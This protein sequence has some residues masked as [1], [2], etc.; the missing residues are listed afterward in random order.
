ME[1][2]WKKQTTMT[3]R[4]MRYWQL[5][6]W[7]KFTK[8]LHVKLKKWKRRRF[9]GDG[10]TELPL[11]LKPHATVREVVRNEL[12]KS[13]SRSYK[14]YFYSRM[15]ARWRFYFKYAY[16]KTVTEVE[17]RHMWRHDLWFVPMRWRPKSH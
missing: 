4:R 8:S 9:K 15:Q 5:C 1:N 11:E 2:Q 6:A 13:W 7:R 3:G 12:K 17:N 16:G 10:C 14:S